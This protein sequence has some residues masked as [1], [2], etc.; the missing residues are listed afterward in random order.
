MARVS[1]YTVGCKLNQYETELIAQKLVDLGFERVNWAQSADL[2]IINS[3]TVT[4][5]AAADSRRKLFAAKRQ[6][7]NAKVIITG[8]Y[9]QICSEL[10]GSMPEV[11]LVVCNDDKDKIISKISQIYPDIDAD[12]C[13]NG[14][15]ALRSLHKH[16]RALIKIQ[17]GCNQHCSYCVIPLGRGSERSRDYNEIIEEINTV[18]SNGYK[19]AILTGVHIGRYRYD[20]DNLASLLQRILDETDIERLR[21]SSVEVNEVDDRLIG[22]ASENK[23]ICPHFHIPLQSGSDKIL[24]S[25][26]RPYK[27]D[28][29]REVAEKLKSEVSNAMIGADIIVGFPGEGEREFE[30]TLGFVEN[31]PIDYLHVFSYSDH[32]QARSHNFNGQIKGDIIKERNH[33]LTILGNLKWNRFLKSQMNRDLPV[34]FEKRFAKETGMLTGLSDNYIRVECPG[35][36]SCFNS[37]KYVSPRKVRDG[38]ITGVLKR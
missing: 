9:A 6:S 12:L 38:R 26:N 30:S 5:K 7:P 10:L 25:M 19:E 17:D 14:K 13:P 28:R 36:E 8:C 16:S 27:T 4:K 34:L 22:L 11:D 20:N 3:C 24:K 35:H 29:Y 32:P 2:Y 21:L 37:I 31:S 15:P 1:F 33:R 18:A 23:R